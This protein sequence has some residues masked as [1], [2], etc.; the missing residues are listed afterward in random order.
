MLS[1]LSGM[2]EMPD[3]I[4]TTTDLQGSKAMELAQSLNL[5]KLSLVLAELKHG[6][7]CVPSINGSGWI[8]KCHACCL[9]NP[10]KQ[11]CF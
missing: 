1:L 9:Q 4:F 3:S 10:K 2:P 11:L 5:Q 7:F 6:A 8:S